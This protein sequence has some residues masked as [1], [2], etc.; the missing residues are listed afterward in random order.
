MSIETA[1][2]QP[3]LWLFFKDFLHQN[4]LG[5]LKNLHCLHPTPRE[6]DLIGL[7]CKSALGDSSEA[8]FSNHWAELAFAPKYT[9][10]IWI[11][12]IWK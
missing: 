3:F 6:S 8:T 11:F 9:G 2:M 10:Q 12:E 7:E 5:N 4:H 1:L